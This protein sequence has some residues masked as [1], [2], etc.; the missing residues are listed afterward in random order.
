MCEILR[1]FA[2]K[3]DKHEYC[4]KPYYHPGMS[5][6]YFVNGKAF[7]SFGKVH[8][9]VAKNYDIAENV[10][11]CEMNLGGFIGKEI[12]QAKFAPLSKFQAVRRD[13][14]VVV[15]DEIPVGLILQTL[16]QAD[17]LCVDAELFDVYK[18]EQIENGYKSVALSFGLSTKDRTLTDDDITSAVKK[19]LAALEQNCGAKLR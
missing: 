4:D 3:P 14:A 11:L 15:K 16:E 13:L 18:G 5:G 19:I 9:L 7:C 6:E 12:P 1:K 17:E 8:P 10:Y 2:L